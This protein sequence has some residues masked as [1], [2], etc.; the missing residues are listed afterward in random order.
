[1]ITLRKAGTASI[2]ALFLI[3]V[4]FTTGVFARSM[5]VSKNASVQSAVA[6][7]N[8]LGGGPIEAAPAPVA[9]APVAPAPAAPVVH[10]VVRNVQVHVHA[11]AIAIA[12]SSNNC[13]LF[14]GFLTGCGAFGAF[15]FVSGFGCLW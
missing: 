11:T 3:L 6:M 1:M 4:L 9:P 14:D 8:R 13:G 7:H 15:P 2:L 5:Q 10:R 12:H